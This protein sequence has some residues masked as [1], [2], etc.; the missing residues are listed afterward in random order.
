MPSCHSRVGSRPALRDGQPTLPT[1][2]ASRAPSPAAHHRG[3]V[4]EPSE[5]SHT[6]ENNPG[7][8]LLSHRVSPAVPSALEGLTSEFEMG[9]GVAPP[10][11]PPETFWCLELRARLLN[12]SRA[13]SPSFD[14]DSRKRLSALSLPAWGACRL[15]RQPTIAG[16]Y[17]NPFRVPIYNRDTKIMVIKPH[18][19]LVPVSSTPCSV[20]T[21]GL[22]T[23]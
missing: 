5:G 14:L 16:G 7:G 23:S 8:D 1:P 15:R 19:R 12:P 4:W 6:R 11:L 10:E 2:R 13:R 17:G 20:S 21:P 9:S 3:R 22:S 18:G